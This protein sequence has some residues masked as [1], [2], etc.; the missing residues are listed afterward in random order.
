MILTTCPTE[1][2][3]FE[4]VASLGYILKSRQAWENNEILYQNEGLKSAG[5]V[6]EW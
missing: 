3:Q 6:T 2:G 4:V 1:V 5:H